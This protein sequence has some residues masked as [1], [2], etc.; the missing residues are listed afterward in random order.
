M[1][2]QSVRLAV[3]GERAEAWADALMDAGALSVSIEDRDLG[4]EAE[5][6]QFGEPGMADPQRLE[7][8]LG[9]RPAR[10][11]LPTVAAM[12]AQAGIPKPT[13]N[14]KSDLSR[15]KTGCA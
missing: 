3:D 13:P 8:Q 14:A 4:T 15:S 7:A 9:G 11:G 10:R 12:L 5:E 2:W 6:A 1:A